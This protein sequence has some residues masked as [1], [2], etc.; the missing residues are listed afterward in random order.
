MTNT[1]DT[2]RHESWTSTCDTVRDLL[3]PS[4]MGPAFVTVDGS[5]IEHAVLREEVDRLAARL[6]EMGLG[7][8]DRIAVVLDNGPEMA[9]VLLAVMAT[10]CAAP[11]NP[12]YRE[13]E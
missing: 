12:A 4:A 9:L 2:A 3:A 1:M 8:G 5:T 10:G 7:A 11:L 13:D 6:R